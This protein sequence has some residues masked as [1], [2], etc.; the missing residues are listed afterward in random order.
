MTWREHNP[1]HVYTLEPSF[2]ELN[3]TLMTWRVPQ[4]RQPVAL[5][6]RFLAAFLASA[7]QSVADLRH[8]ARPIAKAGGEGWGGLC[9]TPLSSLCELLAMTCNTPRL[10]FD[11]IRLR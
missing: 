1:R 9:D 6:G 10:L 3:F 11:S 8:F 7:V 2:L 4:S 5:P